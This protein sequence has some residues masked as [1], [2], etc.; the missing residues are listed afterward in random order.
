MGMIKSTS[1]QPVPL[2][3]AY[4]LLRRTGLLAICWLLAAGSLVG[5][6]AKLKKAEQQYRAGNF[7]AAIEL[8]LPLAEKDGLPEAKLGL[9][10]AYRQIGDF[11]TAAQWYAQAINQ[12]ACQAEHKLHYALSLLQL[13]RC[14]AAQEVLAEYLKLKPYDARRAE[15]ADVCAEQER[16]RHKLKGQAEV[17]LMPFNSPYADF[18][19]A[20]YKEGVVFTSERETDN[21]GRRFTKLFVVS[22]SEDAYAAPEQFGGAINARFHQGTATFN[23]D[24]SEI[25]FTRTRYLESPDK[26]N[27]LEIS[28]ARRLAV[29]G[30]SELAALP[31]SSDDFSVAHP[32]LSPDGQRLYFSSDRPGGFG[33]RDLYYSS[34]ENGQWGAPVNL[35]PAVNSAGDEVFPF[36]ASD[37]KL[38]FSS[39]GHFGL[40]GQ[41]IFWSREQED[42]LWSKPENLGYP[43]NT[44]F[45]DF[46]FILMPDGAAGY[47]TSNRP[48]G[49]G[50]DDIYFF[51]KTG[52]LAQVDIVDLDSGEPIAGARLWDD[53]TQ[54]ERQADAHGRLYLRLPECCTLT[55]KAEGFQERVLAVC[56][57]EGKPLADT[58]FIALALELRSVTD[59]SAEPALAAAE[60]TAA[61]AP[62]LLAAIP[63]ADGAMLR[64][65]V[66]SQ[67]TG[68]PIFQAQLKL[69][70]SNCSDPP[71]VSTDRQGRFAIPLEAGC[72]YQVRA[73]RDSYFSKNLDKKICF[74]TA[75]APPALNIFLTPYAIDAA[76]EGE[77]ASADPAQEEAAFGFKSK[78][79]E[80]S[81]LSFTINVYYDTGRS[82]VRSES[83]PELVNLLHLL[84]DNPDIILEV[85]S[86]TDAN[87]AESFNQQ[88][89]QRRADAVVKYLVGKGIQRERLIAIG[90]GESRLANHCA[91][92][93]P[94]TEEE[95]AENRRTEFRVVGRLSF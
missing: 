10:E 69:F 86:H 72:C 85:S 77:G 93:V 3:S 23:Q 95:H 57:E 87:G 27:R 81:S 82:S 90:H 55:G 83:V 20:F 13:D 12:P 52:R 47:F 80:D 75:E 53:C 2:L 59:E 14:E 56:P 38:Y 25:Y 18:A 73:E 15:F 79:G 68:K 94:C 5:Q 50:G 26:L 88:L 54:S 21:R 33:G 58:L 84:Q 9:A 46:S 42:G 41:D 7:S 34:F 17:E 24:F 60:E 74:Q 36:A 32:A 8:Y 48:G 19:P 31:I 51:R 43:I 28:S 65:T 64:G 35:G 89:S 11:H 30:W 45:D 1:I 92:G 6:A 76:S 40:G 71:I 44:E 67:V 49:I 22:R 66:F 29:G 61:A 37:G 4:S 70:G 39:G 63:S 78:P 16:L 62:G 91:D